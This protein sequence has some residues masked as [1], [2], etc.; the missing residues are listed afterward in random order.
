MILQQKPETITD[1]AKLG[2]FDMSDG[3]EALLRS[4]KR[5]GV[6]YSDMM[7]K[8]PGKRWPLDGLSSIPI[9]RRC[10]HRARRCS[11]RSRG[12]SSAGSRWRRRLSGSRT[13]DDPGKW[14]PLEGEF[15]LEA[16]Q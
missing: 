15:E 16:A 9:R 11:L 8:G 14:S 1:F 3:V 13:P 7:I 10:S 6:E 12:W 5:N 4:L 2:R